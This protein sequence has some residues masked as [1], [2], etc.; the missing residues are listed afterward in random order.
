VFLAHYPALAG[1]AAALVGDRE[2]GH[3]MAAEAFVRIMSRLRRVEDPR[4]YLY[5]TVANLARDHWRKRER[6]RRAYARAG[7]TEEVAAPAG[8][9][10]VRDLVERL[11]DRLRRPVV[12]YYFADMTVAEIATLLRRPQGSIKRALFDARGL[13][14]TEFGLPPRGRDQAPTAHR[15]APSPTTPLAPAPAGPVRD[16]AADPTKPIPAPA[17]PTTRPDD[18]EGM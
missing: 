3:D 12:L 9:L 8:D 4:G 7:P 15:P 11:P 2:L 5:V 6:E 10:A 16:A 18:E 1:Y 14:A 13:L 17:F